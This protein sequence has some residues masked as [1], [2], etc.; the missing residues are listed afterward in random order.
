MLKKITLLLLLLQHLCWS[1]DFSKNWKSH[2]SYVDIVSSDNSE[3]KLYV[4][5]SNSF[6]IHDTSN[7]ITTEFS[8]IDGL[9]SATIKVLRYSRSRELIFVGFENGLI[10]I[11]DEK[12]R[13]VMSLLDISTLQNFPPD[14][15]FINDFF[16]DGNFLYIATGFGI[17]E[18][19]LD[20]SAF[21]NTYQISNSISEIS[22]VISLGVIG[23]FIFVSIEGRGTFRG[24]KRDQ[25]LLLADN[26]ANIQPN[27]FNDFKIFSGQII[28]K[29]ETT[30]YSFNGSQFTEK[31]TSNPERIIDFSI[32]A[33][34][35]SLTQNKMIASSTVNDQYIRLD[36]NF[37]IEEIIEFTDV[38]NK[39]SE[40]YFLNNE[41]YFAEKEKGYLKTKNKNLITTEV[42]SPSGPSRNKILSIDSYNGDTWLTY[43]ELNNKF[44][45][46]STNTGKLGLSRMRNGEWMNIPFSDFES[47]RIVD[48]LIDR[49]NINK[50][51]FGGF[52]STGILKYENNTFEKFTYENSNLEKIEN[53]ERTVV[54]KMKFDSDGKLWVINNRTEKMLKEFSTSGTSENEAPTNSLLNLPDSIRLNAS[55][56]AFTEKG[57]VILA[58]FRDGLIGYSPQSKKITLLPPEVIDD[59]INIVQLRALAIDN[60]G[61]LWIGYD[62]GLRIIKNPDDIIENPES[63]TV[64][65]I[66][67][68]DDELPQELLADQPI[69]DIVIDAQN[70]KWVA[71]N[72]AGVFQFSADGQETLNQFNTLNSPLPSNSVR[73]IA[74]D[75]LSGNIFFATDKGLMEFKSDVVEAQQTFDKFKIFP[76]P[77]RPEYGDI[78]VRIEGLTPAANVKITDIEGNLVYEAQNNAINGV[79]SG[80]VEWDTR[81]FSGN[82][83]ATGVYLILITSEDQLQTEVGKLLI[84]R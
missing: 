67:I 66:I 21:R 55:D 7:N 28:S 22:N 63:V 54:F 72:G 49:N 37:D 20:K 68:L 62:D 34:K 42:I 74:I 9:T 81:S 56:F 31:Y 2:F 14:K 59:E 53:Q 18:Y 17:I 33:S 16:E 45:F 38:N 51:Y 57:N 65:P 10:E 32:T 70:N 1:Q 8:T 75:N 64:S 11:I 78:N 48:V 69:T 71:T 44:G 41:I 15:I 43:G 46:A 58:I 61:D 5:A 77:V 4:A 50:V 79:G 76:N 40:T 80:L 84:V 83:V 12:T 13:K 30:I 27:V 36:E 29:D 3:D 82:K 39:I 25:N 26:W 23:D 47:E 19:D 24:N 6:F 60:E 35:L 73:D 52:L